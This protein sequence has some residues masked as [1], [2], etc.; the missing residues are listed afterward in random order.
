M[1][2]IFGRAKKGFFIEA[3][4][5]NG[6]DFSNT[7][8]FEKVLQWTGILVEPNPDAFA[9]DES[10]KRTEIESLNGLIPFQEIIFSFAF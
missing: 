5:Y 10:I 4:A 2:K 6:L 1:A 7:L 8:Y 3:G 9:G